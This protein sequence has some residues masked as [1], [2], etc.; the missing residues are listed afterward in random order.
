M[1][2]IMVRDVRDHSFS[3]LDCLWSLETG[4]ILPRASELMIQRNVLHTNALG[5]WFNLAPGTARSLIF[6]LDMFGPICLES[7][8]PW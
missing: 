4:I 6:R 1:L 5:Q 2:A 8:T 7:V 3:S